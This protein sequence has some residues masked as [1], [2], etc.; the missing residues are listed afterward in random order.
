MDILLNARY[1]LI[2]FNS[3]LK[4]LQIE[5]VADYFLVVPVLMTFNDLEIQKVCFK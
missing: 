5:I 1:L 4:R 2:S 3:K